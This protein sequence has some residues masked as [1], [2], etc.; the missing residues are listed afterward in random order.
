MWQSV[1]S[2]ASSALAGGNAPAIAAPPASPA[3]ERESMARPGG[4]APLGPNE[5]LCD[6]GARE[7]TCSAPGLWLRSE[8]G[9]LVKPR[10][11]AVNRCAYCALQAALENAEMLMLDALEGDP[12]EVWM[13]LGT[14]T[15][16]LDM[17]GFYRGL[18]QVLRA[19]RRR[20]TG[21]EYA[22][23][24]EY[25][26]GYG[27]RSGGLRRPHWNLTLKGIPAA[28]AA[29]ALAIAAPIWC[30][31]V[32]AEEHAQCVREIHSTGGL[33]RYLALHFHKCSQQPPE[34]WTG[35]RFNC[36]R[37]Y[38]TGMTR[39]AARAR[40]RESIKLRREVWK[41]RRALGDEADAH[42]VELVAQ[43]AY[44]RNAQTRWVLA[45]DRGARLSEGALGPETVD[46]VRAWLA[47][48][49]RQ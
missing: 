40:A 21:C 12:P 46:R 9:E 8:Y 26:T 18:A 2:H 15:A 4:A 13:I 37:G 29:A 35:Q 5:E 20:W 3:R 42:D 27:E 7:C 32:D 22:S 6:V 43:L 47:H 28:D 38:F 39:A 1:D 30:R 10:G 31:H 25:T 16:T 24:V 36:S 41:A 19:L 48:D 49:L 44:R 23:V 45:N 17:E 14:R 34:G 11:G 33:M